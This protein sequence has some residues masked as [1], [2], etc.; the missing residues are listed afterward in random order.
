MPCPDRT[1]T[2]QQPPGYVIFGPAEIPYRR[3]EVGLL[4]LDTYEPP[5]MLHAHVALGTD[6]REGRQHQLA[7]VRPQPH[8]P[9]NGPQLQRRDVLLIL[10][11]PAFG[12]VE[13]VAL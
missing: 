6:A 12:G 4:E 7:R 5:A 8:D 10:V 1:R 2:S 3:I 13:R 11:I 9:L